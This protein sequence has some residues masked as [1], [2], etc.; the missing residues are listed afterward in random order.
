[1]REFYRQAPV[2]T[3][4]TLPKVALIGIGLALGGCSSALPLVSNDDVTGSIPVAAVVSQPATLSSRLDIEDWRR[5]RGALGVALDPQGNGTPVA[6]DNP[7]TGIKGLI[8]PVGDAYAAD[9]KI[10]RA[11]LADIGGKTPSQHLQ[12]RGCRDKAGEWSVS[13]VKPWKKA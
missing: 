3:S 9:E 2:R 11:F 13:D 12:G 1:M 4:R 5:A 7:G 6:W 8:T 10:C